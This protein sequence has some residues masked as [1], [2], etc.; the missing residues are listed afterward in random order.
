MYLREVV[1]HNSG[2]IAK[3]GF[4]PEFRADGGPKPIVLVG[5]NGGG[6]TS[7]LSIIAD[8]MVELAATHFNDVAPQKGMGH[9]FFRVIGATTIRIGAP[10]ELTLTRFSDSHGDRRVIGKAG[11]LPPEVLNS[12]K[13]AYPEL[14]QRTGNASEKITQS[15]EGIDEVFRDGAYAFFQGGRSETPHWSKHADVDVPGHFGLAVSDTLGKPIVVGKTF[16]DLKPWLIDLILDSSMDAVR[17]LQ[18]FQNRGVIEQELGQTLS[19]LPSLQNVNA[20][21]RAIL[22]L[23]GAHF[24]R[25]GRLSGHRKI[26]I[27]ENGNPIIPSLDSLSAG[28]ASLLAMFGTLLRY[29]DAGRQAQ[30]VGEIEGIACI[31]E[32]DAQLHPTLQFEVLPTLIALFPRIQFI[33]SSHSPLF[34]LGMERQFGEDGFSLLNMPDGIRIPVERYSDFLAAFEAFKSTKNFESEIEKIGQASVRPLV[35]GEGE[36]DP[37][38]FRVAAEVLGFDRLLNS[39]DWDWIGKNVSGS[40]QGSGK[41]NL[42]DAWKFLTNNPGFVGREIVLLYDNDANKPAADTGG[43]HI[44]SMPSNPEND[45]VKGGVEILLPKGAFEAKYYTV[46]KKIQGT[47][48]VTTELLDKVAL[49]AAICAERDPK[50]F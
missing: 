29:G 48:I 27:A 26:M 24:V 20:V 44:R 21:I 47:T 8:A 15:G 19:N 16:D 6:K 50:K 25:T 36:T 35:L 4:E 13:G 12:F 40:A 45:I 32:I 1:I 49:C 41:S 38:Y 31:D 5:S 30:A 33:V 37:E 2:P 42:N 3:F 17:I 43:V 46:Q 22:G 9:Q 14:G 34:A 7:V 11:Q 10:Y 18:L 28:Q 39:C 23:A